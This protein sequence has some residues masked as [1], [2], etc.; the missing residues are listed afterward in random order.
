MVK[1]LIWKHDSTGFIYIT[2]PV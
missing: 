1:K 2:W